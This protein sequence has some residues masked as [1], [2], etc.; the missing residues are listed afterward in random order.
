G[1]A[2]RASPGSPHGSAGEPRRAPRPPPSARS[3]PAWPRRLRAGRWPKRPSGRSG[4][5]WSGTASRRGA[6]VRS[7][8]R[9]GGRTGS[10]R[11][12][13]ARRGSGGRAARRPRRRRLR[14]PAAALGAR[15]RA[16][17]LYFL[18]FE[19]VGV[20]ERGDQ[21]LVPGRF[22]LRGALAVA[23]RL[24]VLA[25]VDDD[26]VLPRLHEQ[27]LRADLGLDVLGVVPFEALGLEALDAVA[28]LLLLGLEPV[29]LHAL[30]DVGA[31]RV[32]VGEGERGEHEGDDGGAPGDPALRA[33]TDSLDLAA[34]PPTGSG[35]AAGAGATGSGR[36]S[37]WAAGSSAGAHPPSLVDASVN[38][39]PAPID[40]GAC[41]RRSGPLF[42]SGRG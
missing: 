32:G 36:S 34:R 42:L 13:R 22:G 12:R 16:S 17:S 40:A 30:L 19:L 5:R 33:H 7:R 10:A 6:S 14:S 11:L 8:R 24:G 20:L 28:L 26:E 29:D 15:N 23:A 27:Q 18:V 9:P 3:S 4:S 41:G 2:S 31:Q 39:A 37:S 21:L 35:P 1:R 38:K 25:L